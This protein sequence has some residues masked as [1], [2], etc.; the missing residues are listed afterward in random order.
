MNGC[1]PV[2][3]WH[4]PTQK[5]TGRTSAA[6]GTSLMRALAP[7]LL[8]SPPSPLL[9][10]PLLSRLN[11]I[12]PAPST[13]SSSSTPARIDEKILLAC[14]LPPLLPSDPLR[15]APV[16]GLPCP[17]STAKASALL[18]LDNPDG[19]SPELTAY[20]VNKPHAHHHHLHLP[21]FI[22][23]QTPAS[24][25]LALLSTYLHYIAGPCAEKVPHLL[26]EF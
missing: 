26:P 24:P 13:S 6:E 21:L 10:T 18:F 12:S 4:E 17:P 19:T 11:P 7:K 25:G 20:L 22:A 5:G 16:A 23:H 8:T 3:R 1:C 15:S 2:V 14:P 9:S